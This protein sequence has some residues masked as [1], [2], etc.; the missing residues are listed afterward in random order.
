MAKQLGQTGA[1]VSVAIGMD[2]VDAMKLAIRCARDSMPPLRMSIIDYLAKAPAQQL[3]RRCGRGWT[4]HAMTVDR[5]L[6]ALHM[7]GVVTC[8]EVGYGDQG[9]NRWFYSL[10]A[11]IDPT[12]L[13]PK[14][15]PEK[16]VSYL[17]ISS[18]ETRQGERTNEKGG[19]ERGLLNFS[20]Q[21]SEPD[22]DSQNP[23]PTTEGSLRERLERGAGLKI[24]QTNQDA[25]IES[26]RTNA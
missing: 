26:D 12:S 24:G 14:S 7:L 17:C 1:R 16:L 19:M 3:H 8:D 25:A 13:D 2:R 18:E 23:T 11:D 9:R 20:G 22:G 5:Q 21:L 6:Q 10:A 4:S 15:C